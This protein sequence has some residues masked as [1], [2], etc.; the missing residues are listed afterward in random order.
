MNKSNIYIISII[1][2]IIILWWSFFFFKNDINNNSNSNNNI[3]NTRVNNDVEIDNI[4]DIKE[5]KQFAKDN[6]VNLLWKKLL[7]IAKKKELFAINIK[8]IPEI[9]KVEKQKKELAWPHWKPITNVSYIGQLALWNKLFTKDRET[10]NKDKITL[11]GEW[12][13]IL[14]NKWNELFE[15]NYYDPNFNLKKEKIDSKDIK[16]EPIEIPIP[17]DYFF[18][19]KDL[20]NNYKYNLKKISKKEISINN[21]IIKLSDLDIKW[22]FLVF[23]VKKDIEWGLFFTNNK[24]KERLELFVNIKKDTLIKINLVLIKDVLWL[25]KWETLKFWTFTY[26]KEKFINTIEKSYEINI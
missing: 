4:R 20:K 8:N 21:K 3:T 14:V 5:E 12:K 10:F 26:S 1:C 7:E 6:E 15:N 24:N 16:K 18:Y 11:V 23:K 25:K 22:D 17:Y 9:I 2:I 19:K 13:Y